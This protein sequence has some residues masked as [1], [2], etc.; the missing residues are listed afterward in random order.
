MN[1]QSQ[2]NEENTFFKDVGKRLIEQLQQGKAPWQKHWGNGP[3]GSLPMNPTTGKRYRGAN[4]VLL[5][6]QGYRDPRWLTSR[7]A[8][9]EGAQVREG[10]K[11]I[12]I[13]YWEYEKKEPMCDRQGRPVLNT[14]GKPV[15]QTIKL[16]RPESH[17]YTV[18][19]A[20]QIDGLAPMIRRE[21]D[22]S[23]SGT[24]RAK[25]LLKASGVKVEHIAIGRS[26]Y[27]SVKD[28][29]SVV[30]REKYANEESY[31]ADVLH[32]LAQWT[33]HKS[34]LD[35]PQKGR[36]GTKEYAQE[37]LRTEIAGMMLGNELGIKLNTESQAGQVQNWTRILE[38]NPRQ[39]FHAAAEA[40]E[41]FDHLMAF[42]RQQLQ[43]QEREQR[44]EQKAPWPGTPETPSRREPNERQYIAVPYAEKDEAKALGAKWDKLSQCWFIPKG[45][46]AQGFE[47][48]L[49]PATANKPEAIQMPLGKKAQEPNGIR[50]Y[51]NVPYAEKDEVKALG[52]KWDRAE[53]AW[54]VPRKMDVAPFQK[55]LEPGKTKG[56]PTQT[57]ETSFPEGQTP[58]TA[59]AEQPEEPL[60]YLVVPEKDVAEAQKRGA[61]K[62][63]GDLYCIS[64]DMDPRAYEKWA[65][66]KLVDEY[67]SQLKS[68]RL[69]SQ[70]QSKST[71]QVE[72]TAKAVREYLAVPY[73]ERREAKAAGAK[74]DT[75]AK[76]WYVGEGA[77][78][79]KLK[80]WS[81]ENVAHQ[82]SPA[83]SPREEFGAVLREMGCRVEGEH[84]IMD[85]KPHRIM[86]E[87]DREGARSGFYVAHLDGRPAGYVKNNRSGEETRWKSHG[88]FLS[89]TDKAAF[90]AECARK[91]E[92]RR[93]YVA[94]THENTAV[95]VQ[96]HLSRLQA[97]KETPYLFKKGINVTKGVFVAA[98]KK[99]TCL[100]AQD[101]NGKI[102][103]MQYINEDGTKRFAKDGR[104]EGCFHPVGGMEAVKKAPALVISEGY[105]TA[106]SLSKALGF[107]TIAAFDSGNVASV[108]RALHER[109]PD[110]PIVIAGDDDQH[111]VARMGSNPGREKAEKA[112]QEV[113]G[114]TVFPVF[115]RGE[116]ESD[117]KGFTDFNDLAVK[118][119]LGIQAVARQVQP[120][121]KKA[122]AL[123]AAER[124]QTREKTRT[125]A[126]LV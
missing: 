1:T 105:A 23:R 17:T 73:E 93:E 56:Q 114:Q 85:G 51:L 79:D 62:V 29:I 111:L 72:K 64:K 45:V 10:E 88:A 115:A 70:K 40:E 110:K 112:A 32:Q 108:A 6:M 25:A 46:S 116:R 41:I 31:Y 11:P 57:Q 61:Q 96:E 34:R 75:V 3:E 87:E 106:N 100:P 16:E 126:M 33:G 74:W 27:N 123:K 13:T 91:L 21:R 54:Y 101:V 39:I 19:N 98:D 125:A 104:K 43:K 38:E 102:W 22:E 49:P 109:Y 97:A 113:G 120:V 69:D 2:S 66:P 63:E 83:M 42:E 94:K 119:R 95:R 80:K 50:Q 36:V 28:V 8:A 124:Q 77:D 67:R 12:Q 65:N 55:W 18:F 9:M 20:E 89:Q 103:T 58:K 52:A 5:A 122:I 15:L 48:W 84:P 71:P 37:E 7:Q 86:T 107:G 118:S 68:T 90:Q 81:L 4:A 35:R 53:Q 121:V 60:V 76:S 78:K 82:Q 30:P 99:T 26:T 59:R 47:K 117:P 44:V 92:E 14:Q 24:E